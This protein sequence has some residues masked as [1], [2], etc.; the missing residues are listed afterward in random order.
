MTSSVYLRQRYRALCLP[1]TK[2]SKAN[3][4]NSRMERIIRVLTIGLS[5]VGLMLFSKGGYMQAKAQFAQFLIQRAW[6][7]T[8]VDQ[9]P[10]KPWEWADTYPVAKLVLISERDGQYMSRD[11]YVL[12][13]ASG[14][15]LAFG[16]GLVLAGANVGEVGN[17]IIAG[18]RD[19]HFAILNGV[20]KGRRL[21]LQ[22][23]DGRLK[24]YEVI[25]TNVVHGSDKRFMAR[26]LDERL[27]LITC[28]PFNELG[29][30]ASMRFVVEAI[31]VPE[32]LI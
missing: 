32:N 3:S 6:E 9:M 31:P 5:L 18:H 20:T 30:G 28:Y 11:L 24:T 29:G 17:T 14:R 26:T 10:H 8:L 27:T 7:Q 12:A 4:Q 15:S 21:Q 22:T 13:G 16:P 23:S 1:R 19:T 2:V 25:Q